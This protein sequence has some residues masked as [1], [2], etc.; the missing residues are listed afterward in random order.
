MNI[1][2]EY[3]NYLSE[4]D[5]VD[6]NLKKY[7]ENKIIPLY[8]KFDYA[9]DP[10]HV[11]EVI[12]FS[13]ELQ[14]LIK[15]TNIN[16]VYTVSAYHD[17]GLKKHRKIHHEISGKI[18]RYDKKLLTWFT[19]DEIEIIAEACEDHRASSKKPPRSIYGKIIA[20]SDKCG[21]SIEKLLKRTWLY[22]VS[23]PKYNKLNDEEIFNDM[24]RHLSVKYGKGG[25]AK[26]LLPETL[27]LLGKE[28]NR[29]KRILSS[30]EETYKIFLK[31]RENGEL[32]KGF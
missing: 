25:Y 29:T 21:V 23:D 19:P 15:G 9:H 27:K 13:L 17:L 20:D 12:D 7:I 18:V 2:Q 31:M 10:S 16:I 8:K 1:I 30:R 4:S 11:R 5:I 6:F 24:Y 28:I 22:R 32:K 14:K 3:L 26:F